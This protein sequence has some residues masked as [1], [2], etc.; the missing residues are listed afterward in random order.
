MLSW[1]FRRNK[2]AE[3]EADDED[4]IYIRFWKLFTKNF[5][6]LFLIWYYCIKW[7]VRYKPKKENVNE[8]RKLGGNIL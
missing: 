5:E 4:C 1:N 6:L 8:L 3:G 2:T 7:F